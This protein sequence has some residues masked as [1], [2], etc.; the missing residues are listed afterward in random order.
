MLL[1]GQQLSHLNAHLQ[2]LPDWQELTWQ[3]SVAEGGSSGSPTDAP[4]DG[5]SLKA[6]D[7]RDDE[8]SK[9]RSKNREAQKRFRSATAL[10]HLDQYPA[11]LGLPMRNIPTVHHTVNKQGL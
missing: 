8:L 11:C 1:S 5:T 3:P 9:H 10:P 2:D 7:L 4:G 6:C